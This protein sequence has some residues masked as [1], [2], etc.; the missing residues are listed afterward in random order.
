MD[1]TAVRRLAKRELEPLLDRLGL[2]DWEVKLSF[3]PEASDQGGFLKRGE[4]TRLI[5][6]YDSAAGHQPQSGS[7]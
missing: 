7:I 2:T 6:D 1:Y 3:V 5:V 4:C